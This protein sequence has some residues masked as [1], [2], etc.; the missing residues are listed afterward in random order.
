MTYW[1][2]ELFGTEKPILAMLHLAALP[3]DPLYQRQGSMQDVLNK[4]KKD[5]YALQ[6][7]RV[8]GIIFS[9]E[10]SLPY[11]R[12]VSQVVVGAMGRIIGELMS[13]IQVPFGVDVISDAMASIELAA[14][15]DAKFVRGTFT[16]AY[17]GDGG[18]QNTD[19]ASI[20]RRK[21]DLGLDK[22]RL[23]FFVN[24]ESDVYIND[25]EISSI[26]KSIIFKCAPDGLCVSGESAGQVVNTELI[27]R[28]KAVSG[29]VPVFANTGCNIDN[30]EKILAICDGAV[31]ARTFKVDGR[32]N[33]PVDEQ[34]VKNF[35]ERVRSLRNKQ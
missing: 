16:G 8:D 2:K 9:N 5:L 35:M 23:L 29:K 14:A 34:R 22:L 4:A 20:L 24:Q 6:N 25:R 10:F 11:Q 1:L 21:W 32:F 15:V 3:G 18:I 17:V 19:V 31:V 12:K 28:V 33:N 26:A 30:I 13:E 7:G 27:S